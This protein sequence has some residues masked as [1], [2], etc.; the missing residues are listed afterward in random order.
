MP[1]YISLMKRKELME[2]KSLYESWKQSGLTKTEF[3]NQNNITRQTFY[4]WIKQLQNSNYI[5]DGG[6]KDASKTF[7]DTNAISSDSD[8]EVGSINFL[9]VS[10]LSSSSQINSNLE[11]NQSGTLEISLANGTVINAI[12]SQ[13]RISSFL[14]EIIKD[15]NGSTI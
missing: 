3:C 7:N 12:I 13:N 15:G 9:K 6:N 10:K 11:S 14:Q 2:R 1:S 4:L 5:E 8:L